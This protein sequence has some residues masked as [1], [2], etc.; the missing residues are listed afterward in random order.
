VSAEPGPRASG[1][2]PASD[3]YRLGLRNVYVLPTRSGV[4]YAMVVLAMLVASL[5]YQLSLGY[6][7]SF[8]V[9]GV[10]LVAMLHT[11]RNLS[12]LVLRPGRAD[13]VFAGEIAQLSLIVTNHSALERHALSIAAPGVSAPE[14]FDVPGAVEQIVSLALPVH[15][16]G[17]QAVPRLRL[18]TRFPLGIWRAWSTWRPGLRVLVYPQPEAPGAPLPARFASA[19]EGNASGRGEQ[20]LAALRPWQAGDSLRRIAWKAV[21]RTGSEDLVVRQYEGGDPGELSLEWQQLPAGWDAER[22]LARMTRWVL[23]A[24]ALGARYG[25]QLPGAALAPDAGARHRARCLEVLAT[26]GEPAVQAGSI[27]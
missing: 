20:E 10:A 2:A 21:A 1:S 11:W 24:D 18:E 9:A 27:R 5:N 15:K 7:L 17:W 14:R 19:G 12:A 4:L 25:M 13:P 23:D 26:W 8:L 22:R 6:A 16:R 3:G